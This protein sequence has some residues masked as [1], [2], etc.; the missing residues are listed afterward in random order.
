MR[1]R[2][3]AGRSLS[4]TLPI[5]ERYDLVVVGGGISGL[6][7]AWYLPASAGR[8]RASSFSTTTTISAATP[9][10]TSSRSMAAASSAMAAASRCNRPRRSAA[11]SPRACCAISASTSSG[12]RPRSTASSILRSGCRAACSSTR[13]AFG[14]DVLVTGDPARVTA[15]DIAAAAQCQAAAAF[16]AD[17]PISP[18]SKAQLLALYDRNARSAGRQERRREASASSKATS[19]RDY[20]IKICGCSEEAA[21]CFQGRPLGFYGLGSDAV[22][23]ADARDLGYPGFAGLELPGGA[24]SG[25]ERALHLSF[26]RRQRVAGAPA[27]ALAHSRRRAGQHDGRRGAG[28]VRLRQARRGRASAVRIRLNRPASMSATPATRC[29]V[30]YVRDGSAASRRGAARACWPAST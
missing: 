17:F 24:K 12:S 14:R 4:T 21:N 25:M 1:W 11:R 13:E 26:P 18:E 30:A 16:V 19:Y 8:R 28:A 15:D 20:L 9:S 7:A 2:A 5:E 27:G 23:A 10:A 6:A 22:P 29:V 3:K